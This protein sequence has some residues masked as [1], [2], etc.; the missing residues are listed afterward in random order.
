LSPSPQA[1]NRPARCC[2]VRGQ[3]K[4]GKSFER[5]SL[6]SRRASTDDVQK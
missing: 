6:R 3:V 1:S 4:K 5:Q 2:L